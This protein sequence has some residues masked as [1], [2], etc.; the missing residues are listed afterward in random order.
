[1]V[2]ATRLVFCDGDSLSLDCELSFLQ[3]RLLF[4]SFLSAP[5]YIFHVKV[6][7]PQNRLVIIRRC[8]LRHSKQLLQVFPGHFILAGHSQLARSTRRLDLLSS[9]SSTFSSEI[10]RMFLFDFVRIFS[11]DLNPFFFRNFLIFRQKPLKNL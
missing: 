2:I 9:S 11:F 3:F 4:S 8:Q 10:S 5:A 6:D 1:M 7:R